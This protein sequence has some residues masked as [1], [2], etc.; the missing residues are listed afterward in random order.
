MHM[1]H[2]TLVSHHRNGIVTDGTAFVLFLH[3]LSLQPLLLH[4]PGEWVSFTRTSHSR[5]GCSCC[6]RSSVAISGHQWPSVVISGQQRSSAVISGHQRS[7][8]VISGRSCSRVWLVWAQ[9]VAASSSLHLLPLTPLSSALFPPVPSF[10]PTSPRR[11]RS[12]I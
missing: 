8:A 4:V 11:R 3:I 1:L 9:L 10:P 2:T 5:L 7:S 6:R 12:L